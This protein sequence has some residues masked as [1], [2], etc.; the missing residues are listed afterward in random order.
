MAEI[1][2]D[3]SPS[4]EQEAIAFLDIKTARGDYDEE[5]A[6][7]RIDAIARGLAIS[8]TVFLWYI[9]L[10][11]GHKVG[12]HPHIYRYIPLL[13]TF[14]LAEGEFIAVVT[15]T[16]ASVFGFL[17]IVANYLFRKK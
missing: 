3:A 2:L 5:K 15:T 14:H 1:E 17:V 6:K 12:W 9:I 11:Q 13:P 8:W 10:A 7:I 16:T 4:G